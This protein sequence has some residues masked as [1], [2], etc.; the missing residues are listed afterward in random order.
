ME[1]EKNGN[2]INW[3]HAVLI[4][5]VLLMAFIIMV[6]LMTMQIVDGESY[7]SLIT[8]G[9]S[10]IKTIEAARGDVVDRYGRSL[11]VNR[12]CY[13]I[14]FDKNNIV[15][16]EENSVILEL[17]AIL[18]QN[19]EEWIDS[20]PISKQPPWEY[21]GSDTAQSRLRKRL[22]LAEFATVD[23]VIFRLKERYGLE[24]MSDS[25][26]RKAAGVR[27]EMERVGYNYNTPYT[28]A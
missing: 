6:R 24:D 10:V 13:D 23:D 8:E 20:L 11:A 7:Q 2:I 16:G 4:I 28:F 19:G 1:N 25:D 3:R 9:Y 21:T 5:F 27:Y 26:F 14:V 22:D 12:V 15:K 17:I 18:E